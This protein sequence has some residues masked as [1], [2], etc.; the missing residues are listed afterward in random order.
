MKKFG[1]VLIGLLTLVVIVFGVR[2]VIA[3]HQHDKAV[4]EA[5]C[6]E[7]YQHNVTE[8]KACKEKKPLELIEDLTAKAK[9][10]YETVT[11]PELKY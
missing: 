7:V 5:Y 4:V 6:A 11:L 8:Y 10:Q 2:A 1:K 3:N 9:S